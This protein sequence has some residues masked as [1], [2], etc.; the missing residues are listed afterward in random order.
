MEARRA[1]SPLANGLRAIIWSLNGD[2]EY[3]VSRLGLPHYGSKKGPCGLCRCTGDDNSAETWRDCSASARWLSL[4]WTREA[5]L[6]SAERSQSS[7]FCN[8]LTVLNVHYDY[9]HCK[10]LGSDQIGFGS[11]LDLLVNHLMAGD[12]PL[13]NLKQ[14]WDSIVTSYQRLGISERY[15]SFRKLTMF[16]RKKKCP[17]LKGRAAQIAA[18]GEPLLELWN[19]YMNPEIAVHCKIRTYLRLNIA[20]EKIMKECRTETAFPEPQATNFISYAFAMCNLH[21]E[22]GAHFEEEG[23]KLF[24]SLP[25]LHLLLHTVL[26]CRHINPRLTWCYKGEDVQK[27][28]RSL[29]AS[30]ARGL[31]GPAVTVKMV[32]KLRAAWHLRLSKVSAD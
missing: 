5:W 8:G 13:T 6:A 31:R 7:I 19:Q 22:L 2:A 26:L 15:R 20:M 32:S 17:K 9:M 24:S 14:C 4:G 10:Y 18:F 12:S 28:S 16:Q 27:V 21:L 1:G 30:C 25:K 11:I 3:L 23:Q 29:A